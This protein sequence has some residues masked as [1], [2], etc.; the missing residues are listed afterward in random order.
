MEQLRVNWFEDLPKLRDLVADLE[1]LSHVF[2]KEMFYNPAKVSVCCLGIEVGNGNKNSKNS[3]E[4]K[5]EKR[6]KKKATR[7]QVHKIVWKLCENLIIL[8]TIFWWVITK[9]KKKLSFVS[10]L[11]GGL[12]NMLTTTLGMFLQ[13]VKVGRRWVLAHPA[14]LHKPIRKRPERADVSTLEY[15][16]QPEGTVLTSLPRW[17]L[18][19]MPAISQLSWPRG[20]ATTKEACL[21][22]VISPYPTP[23]CHFE[24]LSPSPSFIEI[25]QRNILLS[26]LLL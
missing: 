20:A 3:L 7:A 6:K 10:G 25:S 21:R 18:L 5:K 11:R 4:G 19:K 14:D 8:Y 9:E 16:Y 22:D 2:P 12:K 26:R 15:V 17:L 23:T 24:D 13:A 1:M